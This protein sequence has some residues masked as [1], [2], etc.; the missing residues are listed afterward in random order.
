MGAPAGWET[1]KTDWATDD[2]PTAT[3]ANRVENNINRIETANRTIDQS[4][5]PSDNTATLSAYTDE[6]AHQLNAII[7][8]D[9]WYDT[10]DSTVAELHARFT[11]S[12]AAFDTDIVSYEDQDF[13]GSA[14]ALLVQ[15]FAVSIPAGSSLVVKRARYFMENRFYR[16]GVSHLEGTAENPYQGYHPAWLGVDNSGK[17]HSSNDETP[18]AD[19]VVAFN[20]T[21]A[22]VVK[23]IAIVVFYSGGTPSDIRAGDGWSVEFGFEET[24]PTT[25]TTGGA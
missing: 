11:V 14:K 3:D 25:T 9:H 23:D 20:S 18:V 24:I 12:G 5:P 21:G 8:K 13:F 6:V 1:P 22:P 7:G 10:P 15:F 4:Q 16:L 17:S 2:A 19:N